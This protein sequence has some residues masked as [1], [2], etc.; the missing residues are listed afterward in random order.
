MIDVTDL[1][2]MAAQF[3]FM[4]PAWLLLLLPLAVLVYL[5]WQQDETSSAHQLLPK[6]LREVLLIGDSGWKKQLPLKL[7]SAGFVAAIVVCAGPSWQKIP[8]PF[9]EDKASLVVVLDN[10]ESMLEKDVAPSRLIRA[11]HK[12]ETVLNSRDGG[13]TGLIVYA[14]TAHTAM[15]T[16]SDSAVFHPYLAA[17]SPQVM[18]KSGKQAETAIELI[19]QQIGGNRSDTVLLITDGVSPHAIKQYQAYFEHSSA[20]LL[21]LAVGNRA[22]NSAHP[23]DM[24]SLSQLASATNGELIELTTDNRDVEKINRLISKHMQLNGESAMPWQDMGYPLLFPVALLLLLWFRKGWVVQWC[25]AL[26]MISGLGVSSPVLA[27]SSQVISQQAVDSVSLSSGDGFKHLTAK[28]EQANPTAL[29]MSE[30]ATQWWWDLWL[31]PDQ[32]GQRLFNQNAYLAAAQVFH[33]P[34]RKGV[35]YYYAGEYVQAHSAFLQSASGSEGKFTQQQALAL[36]NAASALARQRE[37]LAASELL[38]SLLNEPN[39][40]Q[41]LS[42]KAL[43]NLHVIRH[44]IEQIDTTSQ[45]QSNTTDGL[46][47]SIELGDNPQTSNGH[48]EQTSAAVMLREQLNANEIL[49]SEALAEK[50]LK[51]VEADPKYFL[52]T[53]F[54]IQLQ[55]RSKQG[56]A[57]NEH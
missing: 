23:L 2:T 53:K 20:Q 7:L 38:E 33:D 5:R 17:I 40:N 50:W 10:S 14:G 44:I 8:S 47:E 22:M 54:Q 1:A 24:S 37:Y 52:M 13:R 36:Y 4:R 27:S 6:H 21:I 32:Q 55:N 45:S 39:L 26:V 18:P 25:L 9:G 12:I 57:H 15:P 41:A 34:M 46:E 3:H 35:A 49:G 19:D 31:T 11:K 28:T 42:A 51:R 30:R 48:D 56:G 43:Q 16:T 29:S